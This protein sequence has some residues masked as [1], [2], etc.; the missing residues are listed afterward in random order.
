MADD[1]HV[2]YA[3]ADQVGARCDGTGNGSKCSWEPS[4]SAATGWFYRGCG[5]SKWHWTN[6][7]DAW[8]VVGGGGHVYVIYQQDDWSWSP[9]TTSVP[10][11]PNS[12]PS[13]GGIWRPSAQTADGRPHAASSLG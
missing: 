11:P 7:R 5:L 4:S 3:T 2:V 13:R 10:I 12:S 6:G 8:F 1:N 9:G